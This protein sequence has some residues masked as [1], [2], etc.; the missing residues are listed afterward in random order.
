MEAERM[1]SVYQRLIFEIGVGN[2]EGY[3]MNFLIFFFFFLISGSKLLGML[4]ILPT[5]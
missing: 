3:F 5:C 1:T 4:L 2:S